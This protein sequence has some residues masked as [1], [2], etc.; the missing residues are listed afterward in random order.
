MCCGY[1]WIRMLTGF[2]N[3]ISDCLRGT[4]PEFRIR[5]W[6]LFW[7]RS[8]GTENHEDMFSGSRHAGSASHKYCEKCKNPDRRPWEEKKI[9][10]FGIFWGRLWTRCTHYL[11]FMYS[12]GICTDTDSDPDPLKGR[13]LYGYVRV[14]FWDRIHYLYEDRM[15][16]CI[17]LILLLIPGLRKLPVQR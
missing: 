1:S 15:L 10:L 14:K 12:C 7:F 17:S 11:G 4:D 8:V 6:D 2:T 3:G 5:I 9:F 16:R 13:V